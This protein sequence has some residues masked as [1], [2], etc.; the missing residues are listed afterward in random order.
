MVTGVVLA[1]KVEL[2]GGRSNVHKVKNVAKQA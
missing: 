1:Q 2:R